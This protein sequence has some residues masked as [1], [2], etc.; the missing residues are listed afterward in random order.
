MPYLAL[1]LSH[2]SGNALSRCASNVTAK[3][4]KGKS[5]VERERESEI[6][7][8]SGGVVCQFEIYFAVF[9]I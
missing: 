7:A 4:V 1:S 6:A 9:A 8:L 3:A 2:R 5:K